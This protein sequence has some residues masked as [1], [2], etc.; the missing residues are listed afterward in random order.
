MRMSLQPD[1]EH[2]SASDLQLHVQCCQ[3]RSEMPIPTLA[4]VLMNGSLR[5]RKFKACS[6][7][8]AQEDVF[9]PTLT[10]TETLTL[11]AQLRLPNN[12]SRADRRT[13]VT[14]ALQAMG[15]TR[16]ART[17]VLAALALT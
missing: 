3:P 6:A 15:L 5:A 17:Q 16:S 11:H 1:Q 4:Q 12:T 14:D 13:I 10:A 7:Y 8:V 9:E 2:Q